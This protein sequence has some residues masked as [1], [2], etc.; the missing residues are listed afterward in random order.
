MEVSEKKNKGNVK[1][2][3]MAANYNRP[4]YVPY[5]PENSVG[6]DNS[7]FPTYHFTPL[8][9][10]PHERLYGQR[11]PDQSDKL[12]SF[13]PIKG[14]QFN[15]GGRLSHEQAMAQQERF[16]DSSPA[17]FY[18]DED[19]KVTW[20][21]NAGN[22]TLQEAMLQMQNPYPLNY[23][24]ERQIFGTGQG[25]GCNV[26]SDDRGDF[27]FPQYTYGSL[28]GCMTANP[29]Q[30]VVTREPLIRPRGHGPLVNMVPAG[31]YP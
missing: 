19:H 17:E 18:V 14:I 8:A 28:D 27:P 13:D 26:Q 31:L 30:Q 2:S 1:T 9:L 20:D 11:P 4:W 23:N 3:L 10:F 12:W 21:P 16:Q 7:V 22:L 6:W 24:W 5:M 15:R 25:Y 29:N